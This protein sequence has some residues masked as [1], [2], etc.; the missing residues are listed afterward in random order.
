MKSVEE[1]AMKEYYGKVI[2]TEL[3]EMITPEQTALIIVDLQNDFYLDEG[4]LL[5]PE[6]ISKLKALI[7]STRRNGV[8]VVYIQDIVLQN[9]LSNSALWVRYYMVGLKTYDPH[10]VTEG[11]MEGSQEH[12]I[13]DEIEP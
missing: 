9:R 4:K 2:L 11:V 3:D 10:D 7:Q 1:I 13:V 8:M 5:Y 12:D 6:M